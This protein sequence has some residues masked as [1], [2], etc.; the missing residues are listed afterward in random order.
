M[1][2]VIIA[3]A[4]DRMALRGITEDMV[5]ACLEKPDIKSR[6]YKDRHVHYKKYENQYVAVVFEVEK[7][8]WRV[9]TVIWKDKPLP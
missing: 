6:G 8:A 5:K 7:T 9:I 1:R 4:R 2:L 3:H